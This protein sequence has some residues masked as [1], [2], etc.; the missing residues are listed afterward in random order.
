MQGKDLI[1]E[2]G[3]NKAF[4]QT[5]LLVTCIIIYVNARAQTFQVI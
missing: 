2:T 5:I 1:G 4:L 3:S